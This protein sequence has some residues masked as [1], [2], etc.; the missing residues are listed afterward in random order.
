MGV[1]CISF[2]TNLKQHR[3]PYLRHAGEKKN[4]IF[5]FQDEVKHDAEMENEYQLTTTSIASFTAL[6]TKAGA[7]MDKSSVMLWQ[8]KAY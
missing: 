4:L 6:V 2:L 7:S 8:I 1:V 3:V 5:L